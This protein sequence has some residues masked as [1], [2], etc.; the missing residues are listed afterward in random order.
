MSLFTA[1]N[2][3]IFIYVRIVVVLMYFIDEDR[4]DEFEGEIQF[5]DWLELSEKQCARTT[6]KLAAAE[7]IL[8]TYYIKLLFLINKRRV[9]V[10]ILI[11][12]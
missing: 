5:S 8:I 4:I 7:R 12:R 1:V 11:I 2:N 9:L 3:A 10:L 6:P